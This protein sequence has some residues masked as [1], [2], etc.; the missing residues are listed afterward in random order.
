MGLWAWVNS[1]WRPLPPVTSLGSKPAWVQKLKFK[2]A[3]AFSI[4]PV[5]RRP[6]GYC[7]AVRESVAI[8]LI[9]YMY[10]SAEPF[11]NFRAL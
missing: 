6:P 9:I 1:L 10:L 4:W 8:L 2:G 11:D 3:W 7:R 5:P